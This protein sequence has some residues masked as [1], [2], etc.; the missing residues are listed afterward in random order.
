MNLTRTLL[1]PRNESRHAPLLSSHE[2]CREMEVLWMPLWRASS[3]LRSLDVVVV[4]WFK[5]IL[6]QPRLDQLDAGAIETNW[7]M[8]LASHTAH[9]CGG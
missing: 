7:V 9:Q 1:L 2:T 3:A 6:P 5:A 8:C 4:Y